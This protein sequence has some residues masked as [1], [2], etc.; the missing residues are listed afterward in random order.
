MLVGG[1][2]NFSGIKPTG[3]VAAVSLNAERS[4]FNAKAPPNYDGA[5]ALQIIVCSFI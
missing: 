4:G 3:S 2:H 1:A 5:F